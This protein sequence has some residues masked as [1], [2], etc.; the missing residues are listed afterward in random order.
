MIFREQQSREHKG[1]TT[2]AG[3]SAGTVIG[4][5]TFMAAGLGAIAIPGLGPA[6]PAAPLAITIGSASFGAAA[7]AI[8]GVLIASKAYP[9]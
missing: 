7:G 2:V 1:L 6:I 9:Q 4:G 8:V 3:G 5:I